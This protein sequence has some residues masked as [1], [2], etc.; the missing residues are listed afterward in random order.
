MFA[1]IYIAI[2]VNFGL[3]ACGS[4][5]STPEIESQTANPTATFQSIQ[6]TVPP[7]EIP[8]PTL[9]PAV[10][11]TTKGS[12]RSFPELLKNPDGITFGPL[13]TTWQN[14]LNDSVLEF[15]G[16]TWDLCAAGNGTASGELINANI[17]WTIGPPREGMHGNEVFFSV[18]NPGDTMFRA[19]VLGYEN[20]AP[21]LK[22][23]TNY[24]FADTVTPF[25]YQ[26]DPIPFESFELTTCLNL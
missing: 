12:V 22:I 26:D 4:N 3:A 25:I 23:V 7:R 18:W 6:V 8:T 19:Y 1:L 14:H 20:D 2:L 13:I 17:V 24:E 15:R 9:A 11:P 5:T 16:N 21:V 10:T